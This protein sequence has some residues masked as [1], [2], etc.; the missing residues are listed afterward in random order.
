MLESSQG[1]EGD[2]L[3][4]SVRRFLEVPESTAVA[5]QHVVSKV[6]L[7]HFEGEVQGVRQIGVFSVRHGS[8]RPIGI[9]NAGRVQDLLRIGSASAE[10]LW[11]VTED[12]IGQAIADIRDQ[13]LLASPHSMSILRDAI[14]LHFARSKS[15]VPFLECAE[16]RISLE[17]IVI[18]HRE[19]LTAFFVA[20][21]GGLPTE[22]QLISLAKDLTVDGRALVASDAW[23][24]ARVEQ[25]FEM[26]KRNASHELI[27]VR[28]D[29]GAGEFLIGDTPAVAYRHAVALGESR[30]GW[31]RADEIVMPFAPDLA[32]CLAPKSA[33][34][35]LERLA[36]VPP[37]RV[38]ILNARQVGAAIDYVFH[39]PE[40]EFAGF[41]AENLLP[42]GDGRGG[43]A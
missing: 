23:P 12:E 21:Y 1:A 40:A 11:K 29:A 15:L 25:V 38:D 24:R 37:S 20:E 22:N 34:S 14:A 35:A 8:Q 5:G 16:D 9:G 13:E 19:Q 18:R 39:R 42:A 4:R 10:K 3:A 33:A 28:P 27:L 17:T 43:S 6:V 31:N 7:K 32:I 2:D 26:L 30:I 36:R 41:I